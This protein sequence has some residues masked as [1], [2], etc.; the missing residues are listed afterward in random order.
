MER[1][2]TNYQVE[3]LSNLKLLSDYEDDYFGKDEMA[4]KTS[5]F[6]ENNYPGCENEIGKE[7]N[8]L[9]NKG[10]IT[11]EYTTNQSEYLIIQ[12][13]GMNKAGI[14]YLIMLK[15]DFI[16]RSTTNEQMLELLKNITEINKSVNEIAQKTL[17]D[18][19]EQLST[20]GANFTTMGSTVLSLTGIP[21]GIIPFIKE[22]INGIIKLK[23][24]QAK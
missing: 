20:I 23:P 7:L 16:E 1:I 24:L 5:N 6:I 19:I 12:E 11:F 3:W 8:V 22:A 17:L 2:L 9:K 14:D 13:I 15:E 10:F 4:E 18:K 21:Q